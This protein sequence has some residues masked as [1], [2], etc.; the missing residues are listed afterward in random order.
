M[1]VLGVSLYPEKTDYEK[2]KAYLEVAKKY[3]FSR[4]FMNLLLFEAQKVEVILERLEKTITYGNHLG[5][6][7]YIDVNPYTLKALNIQPNELSYFADLG[8]KGIRLDMGFTGKEEAAMT[9][10]SLDLKIEINMSND[11]HYLERIFDYNPNRNQL[12][13]CHNFFPQAYTGLSIEHFIHCSK[14]FLEK[15]LRTAAFV[16]SQ[17]GEI[18]PWPLH[19]GL[20]TIEEHRKLSI[21]A[22][23]KHMKCLNVVDDLIIG[24]AYASET[25]LKEMSEAFFENEL[26]LSVI[27]EHGISELE[28]KIIEESVHTYRGDRS[29]YMIRSSMPRFTYRKE[30]I[31]KK[32]QSDVIKRG[33][34]LI[35]NEDYGQYKGEVQIALKDRP[36][37][38]RVNKIGHIAPEDQLLLEGLQPYTSFSLKINR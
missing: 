38:S 29:E 25:E 26:T 7:T 5:F 32:E 14:R 21:G 11:D 18:G 34:V 17:T 13:G 33:D 4:I 24:N 10:N 2:D 15:N 16:T 19:E 6:E 20:C 8:V 3:G 28:Q 22:Q 35:L 1:G 12:V 37:D 9:K 31:P 30:S 23:V 36:K 27:P